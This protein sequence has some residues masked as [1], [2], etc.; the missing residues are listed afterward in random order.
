MVCVIDAAGGRVDERVDYWRQLVLDRFGVIARFDP[1]EDD[2]FEQSMAVDRV[3][4][5]VIGERRGSP[6]KVS[7]FSGDND[8]IAACLTLSGQCEWQ[9]GTHNDPV[10]LGPGSL[11]VFPLREACQ[12]RFAEPT[13]HLFQAFPER[14]LAE[15][16]PEWQNQ[17]RR[18]LD[19]S[20]NPVHMLFD[21]TQSLLQHG[22]GLGAP[23]RNAGGEMLVG[24]IAS[25]LAA[26]DEGEGA[27]S[28]RMRSF[29]LQRIRN[30][31]LTH[32]CD[33]TL[34]AARIAEGVGLSVRYLHRLF[35]SEP[36]H[37]MQ[38]VMEH[39]LQRCHTALSSPAGAKLSIAE[40]AYANGFNDA[41][42]FSRVFQKRF[43]LCPRDVREKSRTAAG[44]S[45]TT[46]PPEASLPT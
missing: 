32:L 41:A 38:W 9:S 36:Q 22:D 31:V 45:R 42:H 17:A 1:I 16:N 46:Q 13:H 3:G 44:A 29:H 26:R 37:L 24:L 11:I 23:C 2:Q 25:A 15:R 28:T 21:L 8:L 20:A 6:F 5:V 33:P 43:G 34:D 7:Q 4:D 10:T 40:I 35:A 14:L 27:A 18:P 30:Y 12:M 39:R 19:R